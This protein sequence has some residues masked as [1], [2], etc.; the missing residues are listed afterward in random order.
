MFHHNYCLILQNFFHSSRYSCSLINVQIGCYFVKEVEIRI[1]YH[2][3]YDGNPLQF[4]SAQLLYVPPPRFFEFKI[5]HKPFRYSSFVGNIQQLLNFTIKVFRN[6]I[7]ILRLIS[8]LNIPSRQL[9]E[10]ILQLRPRIPLFYLIPTR[11]FFFFFFCLKVYF[12]NV[13]NLQ[14]R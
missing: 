9:I 2:C 6:C 3:C 7:Y 1:F 13:W 5:L 4:A 14:S 11:L 8:H 10:V 12:A